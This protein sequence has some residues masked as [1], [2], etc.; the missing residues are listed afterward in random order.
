MNAKNIHQTESLTDKLRIV[1]AIVA[2]DLLE[3]LKNKNT[4][5]VILTSLFVVF[6]YRGIPN[7]T[8]A[9]EKTAMLVYDAGDSAL[10]ALLENAQTLRVYGFASEEKMKDEMGDAEVPE[11]AITIPA[12][13]DQA[14]ERGES[15]D[16][17]GYAIHWLKGADVQALKTTMEAEISRLLGR[18]ITI[19]MQEG[20]VYN[21]AR[22]GGL[23]MWATLSLVF[24]VI[25][26]GMTM[27]PHLMLEEKQTHTLEALLVSPA[28]AGKVISA[29][30]I[31]GLFY[32]LAG[33]AVTMAMY[34]RLVVHWWLIILVAIALALFAVSIG[35]LLGIIVDNRG[36]LTLW[37]WVF[38]VPFLLPIFISQLEG[39]LPDALIQVLRYIPTVVA[40]NLIRTSYAGSIPLAGTLLQV[41][42]LVSWAGLVM[43]GAAWLVSRRDREGTFVP[44]GW[45]AQ[46]D[47][48]Q[49]G[50]AGLFAPLLEYLPWVRS[51]AETAIQVDEARGS[52]AELSDTASTPNAWKIMTAIA[53]K[54]IRDAIQNKLVI[55][56]I[57]GSMLM[58]VTNSV[59]PLLLRLQDK[60]A[61]LAYD[62]G[63]STLLRGLTGQDEYV[64]GLSDTLNEME[65]NVIE[66]PMSPIGLI[67]PSDF[68]Q[69]AGGD[70]LIEIEAYAAHWADPDRVAQ[71][72]A[73]FEQTL[74][75]A[76]WSTVEINLA[77]DRLYPT[78]ETSGQPMTISLLLAV[79]ML[80]I[81]IALV[82]LLMVEEKE[83]HTLDALL[84]SPASHL[85]IVSGKA[86]AG[87]FYA[88]V[89]ALVIILLNMKLFVHWEVV[90]LATLTGIAF[91][92]AIGLLVGVVSDSPTTAGLWGTL[93]LLLLIV[94]AVGSGLIDA[95]NWSPV[96]QNVLV[97]TPGAIIM[98]MYQFA[99][100]G[101]LPT[102]QLLSGLL[103]IAIWA[104]LIY[105]LVWW[106][107][108]RA[109]R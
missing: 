2:K 63:R 10:I 58:V 86:L 83:A 47:I 21:H 53:G 95:S 102:V 77:D 46:L 73:F 85:Q 50:G 60:P 72:V 93:L 22:S 34:H 26:I 48:P 90:F 3:A 41:V 13:F 56:I 20:R 37:A 38:L 94:P 1:W 52:G 92:V 71:T 35:L 79:G 11:L 91:A 87:A 24:L 107:I 109:D 44:S 19:R 18:D 97:W 14:L 100:L 12:G 57:L 101:E 65:Q 45:Q 98:N 23:G 42:W 40:F 68:D 108:R 66:L 105:S 64:L 30:A 61:A 32:C 67:I 39:L 17:Q 88:L 6:A 76:S 15:P 9:G 8:S 69:R 16:L 70:E 33:A 36:Q 29:K 31:V 104:A 28:S 55:S 84:V 43:F 54:D 75:Q 81:G 89:M 27:I 99:M 4:I 49:G 96:V 106:F 103:G 80:T 5:S 59:L 25:M 82:P 62:Q 51:E 78:V 7:L 74:S